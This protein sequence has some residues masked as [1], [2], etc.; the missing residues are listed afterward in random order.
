MLCFT[1]IESK[2]VFASM[3]DTQCYKIASNI[4]K[5]VENSKP[6][7]RG[8][9]Y[10]INPCTGKG[11]EYEFYANYYTAPYV[12]RKVFSNRDVEGYKMK[13]RY[14]LCG[15]GT[16]KVENWALYYM[17]GIAYGV[18]DNH[19]LTDWTKSYILEQCNTL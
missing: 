16:A 9:R 12:G 18:W 11:M 4:D 2:K 6:E 14:V 1:G 8:T 15:D 10:A 19:P 5:S 17:K 7:H 13:K 3:S